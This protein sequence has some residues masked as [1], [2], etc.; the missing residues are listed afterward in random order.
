LDAPLN[1]SMNFTCRSCGDK[2][3]ELVLDLG[4]QPL[5]NNLLNPDDIGKEEPR[6]PLRIFVC[7]ACWMIQITDTVPPVELFSDYLYFSSFSDTML[8]HSRKAV[9]EHISDFGL[10]KDSHVVEIASNDGYLLK[11]RDARPT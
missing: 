9:D 3:G 11:K 2:H 6:F 5:A 7:P 8:K 10:D 1:M 4:N